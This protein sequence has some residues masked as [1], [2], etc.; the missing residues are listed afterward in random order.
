MKIQSIHQL[1]EILCDTIT[2]LRD[3]TTPAATAEA[4]SNASGTVIA[5][6]R[7]H[8]EYAR[9]RIEVPALPFLD[10][11]ETTVTPFAQ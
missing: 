1:R 10:A 11:P 8:L 3:G 9:Q 4:V 5:S 6:L 2:G 7:I